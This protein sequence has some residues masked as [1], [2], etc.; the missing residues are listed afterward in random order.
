MGRIVSL[1]VWCGGEHEV[2][3]STYWVTSRTELYP[4]KNFRPKNFRPKNQIITPIVPSS[5]LLTWSKIPMKK[6]DEKYED[7]LL[8]V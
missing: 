8:L 7:F 3:P 6:M 4:S 2:T 5:P 1:G